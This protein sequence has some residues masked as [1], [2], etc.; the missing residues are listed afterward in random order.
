MCKEEKHIHDKCSERTKLIRKTERKKV[1]A[2][3]LENLKRLRDAFTSKQ[4][5]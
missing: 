5:A 4:V 1:M 2:E 3:T